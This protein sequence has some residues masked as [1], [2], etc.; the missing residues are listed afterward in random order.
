MGY[1]SDY[2]FGGKKTAKKTQ[3][4]SG[5]VAVL[6]E[7]VVTSESEIQ[8]N[9]VVELD[10]YSRAMHEKKNGNLEQAIL[11]LEKSCAPPSIY[12]VH[13]RELFKI[14]RQMNKEDLKSKNYHTVIRRVKT[15]V[16]YDDEMIDAM[17]KHWGAQQTKS[18]D[19]THY[20]K[21][22]NLKI[23]DVKALQKA[24][25]VLKDSDAERLAEGLL[26]RFEK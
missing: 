26:L 7:D 10:N 8:E 20:D 11:L 25:S 4:V 13:Y 9:V 6:D 18:L 17:L 15:M 16:R 22:R 1:I 2:F 21:D 24:A 3:T 12:K 23:S 14:W 5:D 19:V